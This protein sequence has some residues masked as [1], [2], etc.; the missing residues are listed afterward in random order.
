MNALIKFALHNRMLIV[1]LSLITLVAGSMTMA[2]LPIDIF[3][4]LTRPRVTVMTECPGLSPEEVETLV[5][6]PLEVAFNGATGV[7]AVRSSSGIGLSVI[8]VEFGWN[9]NIYVARQ[10]VNERIAIVRDRLPEEVKPELAP[11]SSIMGQIVMVGMYS[12]DGSTKPMDVRTLADWAVRPRLLTIPGVAQVIT[13]GGGRKQYQVKVDAAQLQAHDVSLEDVEQ[14]LKESNQNATGGYLERG[15]LEFLV[16]GIGRVQSISDLEQTVVKSHG[17]RSVLVRDVARVVEGPQVK[18][19]DSSVNGHPAVVL[20]IAKQPTADTRGLTDKIIRALEEL[21]ASLPADIEIEPGLYQ[22]RE[23]IDRG[24]HNVLEALRDGA[25]LVLIILFLFLMNVRTTLITL[26]AIPLSIVITGLVFYFTGQSINVMTLG[27]LAVAMGELVDDAIVDIENVFRRLHLNARLPHPK[28]SLDVIYHASI[29]VRGCIVFGTMLVILVFLPLFALSG[30][31]GR[32]FA[33]LGVAYIVSILAS[34]LVSLTVTPV[35]GSLLLAGQIE[36]QGKLDAAKAAAGDASHAADPHGGDSYLLRILKRGITPVIHFSM[37]PWG[38][39]LILLTVFAAIAGSGI[40][41]VSLGTDFL[42]PFDE[43]AAQV[44]I[45]LPPGSSLETSNRVTRMVDKA[46]RKH[47]AA[48]KTAGSTAAGQGTNA[49]F[50]FNLF[51]AAEAGD[52]ND[53]SLIKALVR[54]SG[55]AE[56]DEHAEG[57]HVTE[58]IVSMNPHSGVSRQGALAILRKDLEAIPG[59]EYEVEQPLAHLIS[60][61]LSGVSA[62][63]AIKIYGDDL[64]T[65]R[66]KANEIKSAITGIPGLAPPVVEAQTLI[67]QLRIELNREQLALNGLTPGDVNRVVETALNGRT[68]STIL[69]GARTFDLVVRMDDE[70]RTDVDAIRRLVISLPSGGHIPLSAVSRIYDGAGPNT[71][72]HERTK[73]R[74]TI[75]GN[76]TDRDLGSVVADIQAAVKQK[77]KLPEGYFIEYGGQFEAQQE[78]TRLISILSLVSLAG[79]FLVL[80]TQFPSTRIVL[81]IMLALPTAFVGGA[82]ALWLTNQT[83]TVA[84]MVGFISLGGIAARNGILLVA[85]YLHLMK[86]EGEEFTEAMILRG[87]LERLAPV[88]MTAL[89]AGIGLV[90]LVLGGQQPGKEILYPV[91]TVILGGLI[92]STICEYVVHPGLFWRFSGSA[93]KR[94]A[95][96]SNADD[97]Q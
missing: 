66:S 50:L 86:E 19:G 48:D 64:D 75:R 59:V 16:R 95:T 5:T 40:L 91:A 39:K 34:L 4:S 69:E 52:P 72:S 10:I 33:P 57:V 27:G 31:E 85:H 65:L 82:V 71:I 38:L 25:V 62:Q 2:S 60:H 42:P 15:S 43:G 21:K 26:T 17:E 6:L 30:V 23:F 22:Q 20:T 81:Q 12:K 83:L 63:I 73:R 79:V 77:V 44:N 61:M 74:I 37:N 88:L 11:I 8:Y 29:E 49:A 56:M 80:F 68:V 58:Y 76:T 55:R 94:L 9:T 28:P 70:Y 45:T 14:A 54:R 3:P 92:T 93:A 46:F 87:S 78:A 51:S 53:K 47:M 36:R 18:R 13:M 41:V 90:P 96:S 84:G 32:L 97:I 35:L 24:I 1:C 89:T 7:E 67:P